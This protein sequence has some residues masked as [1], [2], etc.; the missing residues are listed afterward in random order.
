[1]HNRLII[2]CFEKAL[3]QE[4][5]LG[6]LHPSKSRLA[7]VLSDYIEA[8]QNF[9]F[10]ERRLRDYYNEALADTQVEIKQP[11][12]LNGLASFLGY[13]DYTDFVLR[14]K[15]NKKDLHLPESENQV[16]ESLRIKSFL[17]S[18]KVS[19]AITVISA[20]VIFLL[21]ASKQQRWMKWEE[22]N[23]VET[24]FDADKLSKGELKAYK[25][26]RIA[27][28]KLLKPECD[29]QFFNQDG[30]VRVWYSKNKDGSLD[31]FSDYGLHPKTGKTLKPITKYI[32]E[33]YICQE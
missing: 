28:F 10:G 5:E 30:S 1:M 2:E 9:Q 23:Y 27:S 20:V 31:Y 16:V 15:G 18:H 17:K 6:N 7:T 24:S 32:I 21:M 12:V 4:E 8:H 26:D 33:K 14:L 3:K 25:E 22:N 11:T 29:T 19:I 13:E